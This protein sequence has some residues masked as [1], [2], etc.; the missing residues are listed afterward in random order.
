M[1]I[2]RSLIKL[3]SVVAIS[4]PIIVFTTSILIPLSAIAKFI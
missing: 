2:L 3:I 4:L 1:R